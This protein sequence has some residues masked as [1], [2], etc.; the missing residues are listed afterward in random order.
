MHPA[1]PP[2]PSQS[3]NPRKRE[4]LEYAVAGLDEQSRR[5]KFNAA[6]REDDR[7]FMR[8]LI[9]RG[10]RVLELGCGTGELLCSAATVLR[11]RRRLRRQ[12]HRDGQDAA[13]RSQLCPG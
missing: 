5:G 10:K 9:P 2:A 11:R 12:N 6:Y 3:S 13:P 1:P 7:K 8:F 4:F